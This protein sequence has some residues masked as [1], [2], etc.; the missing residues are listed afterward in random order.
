MRKKGDVVA[1]EDALNGNVNIARAQIVLWYQNYQFCRTPVNARL[2]I[3]AKK[4]HSLD[5]VIYINRAR[6]K[7]KAIYRA[8][9]A[10]RIVVLL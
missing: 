2:L 7:K 5:P 6:I 1:K 9:I 10:S 3:L 8:L 4:Q